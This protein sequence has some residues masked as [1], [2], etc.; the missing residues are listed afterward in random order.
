MK[1]TFAD[2]KYYLQIALL[3]A[4]AF[5]GGYATSVKIGPFASCMLL[6]P[7]AAAGG[8]L[9]THVLL[10][11]VPFVLFGYFLNSFYGGDT[12]RSVACALLCGACAAACHLSAALIR[13][14]K[15]LR[16]IAGIALILAAALP[17]LYVLGNPFA[18]FRSE[19]MLAEYTQNSYGGSGYT[20]G[21]LRYD[22]GAGRFYITV[23]PDSDRS[24]SFRIA[25]DGAGIID[26]YRSY[27]LLSQFAKTRSELVSAL[28]DAFPDDKFEVVSEKAV[29]VFSGNAEPE[30]MVFAVYISAYVSDVEFV[31]RAVRYTEAAR[32]AGVRFAYLV[33]YGGRAGSYYRTLTLRGDSVLEKAVTR[34]VSPVKTERF[35]LKLFGAR[36]PD[37]SRR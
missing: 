9:K 17:C 29:N 2:I 4:L 14:K 21:G 19:K 5:A 1:K 11:A 22:M 3:A 10:K 6:I 31:R 16:L 24:Q 37:D 32:N 18:A 35:F 27:A 30:N 13:G 34:Y 12:A 33:F 7:A 28:R 8:F 23:T 36:L 15:P 20:A 25:Y 26:G